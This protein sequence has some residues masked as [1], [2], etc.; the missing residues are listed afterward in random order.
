M[1][2]A[3]YTVHPTPYTLHPTP[4]QD[5]ASDASTTNCFLTGVKFGVVQRKHH[6]RYCGQVRL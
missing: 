5:W 4:D 1:H 6:C 3:L 2:R